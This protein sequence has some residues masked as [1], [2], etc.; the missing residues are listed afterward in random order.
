[1]AQTKKSGSTT[2]KKTTVQS[3]KKPAAKKTATK[4]TPAKSKKKVPSKAS[5]SERNYFAIMIS[6]LVGGLFILFF[7]FVKGSNLWTVIRS[8]GF[9]FFGVGFW[10]LAIQCLIIGVTMALQKLSRSLLMTNI[11]GFVFN[12]SVSGFAHICGN[13]VT[14]N[15]KGLWFSQLKEAMETSWNIGQG[16]SAFSGGILG[17]F[18]GGGLLHLLGKFGAIVVVI[19][20][21]AISVFLFLNINTE[22]IGE[23]LSLKMISE[24]EKFDDSADV[25]RIK[26]QEQREVRAERAEIERQRRLEAREAE[27]KRRAEEAEA[28][29]LAAQTAS[30]DFSETEIE[31]EASPEIDRETG[32]PLRSVKKHIRGKGIFSFK[33]ESDETVVADDT[34]DFISEGEATTVPQRP[35]EVAEFTEEFVYDPPVPFFDF[36]PADIVAE[37]APAFSFEPVEPVA[38]VSDESTELAEKAAEKAT[39]DVR[40]RAVDSKVKT[41]EKT[42]KPYNLPPIDCLNAPSTKDGEIDAAEM[43]TTARKLIEILSSFGVETSL[44]GISR[45]PS[46]TRYELTPGPGVKISKITTLSDDI[47][48]GLA[49][50]GVRI[51]APIPNMAAVGVEV[52]NK[53]KSMVTMREIITAPAYRKEIQ[54]NKLLTVALGVDVSGG[55]NFTDLTKMPHLLVAGTTGSG[56]SVC[57]NCMIAS[58]L[59]NARPDQVKLIM[60]DPKQVEFSVYNGIPHLLVPVITDA[61]KAAGSLAW[62]VSEMDNRYKTFSTHG[63]RDIGSYNKHIDGNPEFD[64]MPHILVFIDEL[65]DLMMVSPKEVE[66]SICRLAQ[67][68]RAAGIHLVVATQ[69]PS[70]D[71]ITG[72][73]KSNIPSRLSLAVSSAVDSKII[74]DAGGAETLL[75]NGDMLFSP[76]GSNKPIRLQGAYLSDEEIENLVTFLK[77]QATVEYS[78]EIMDE[79]E[80][81][82]M[83]ET[84]SKKG[85]A[86]SDDDKPSKHD[87]MLDDAIDLITTLNYAS[88]TIIQRKLSV[89]FSRAG[90][91]M[92]QLESLGYISPADGNKPRNVLISRAQYLEKKAASSGSEAD[93]GEEG[94]TA[95]DDYDIFSD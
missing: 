4:K 11:F 76:V 3:A 64:Y 26:R 72:T 56:K 27:K 47:A 28:A 33:D 73:I 19:V 29:R 13:K 38:E 63:V 46:V 23:K 55:V 59:F 8:A 71:V 48:L 7:C 78:S 14:E 88:T 90:R 53:S 68:A 36:T 43:Q 87:P 50:S 45:G 9:A 2:K 65:N 17:G 44:A 18:F 20:L 92:D 93:E 37:E 91:I 12:A 42:D 95:A 1:M 5:F 75:G 81:N 39:I 21:I 82:A 58:V 34:F 66:D 52:P 30:F 22:A 67:K 24:K 16:T 51:L 62:A 61:R 10:L 77:E 74:L 70:V 25:R 32:L 85:G 84:P 40:K 89:G 86:G 15:V 41:P 6:Y 54:K 49:T 94:S 80:K 31:T 83:A 79:I 35:K 60:I 69:R 57:L